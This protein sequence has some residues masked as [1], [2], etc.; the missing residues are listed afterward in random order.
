MGLTYAN[1][2]YVHLAAQRVGETLGLTA[3]SVPAYSGT[4]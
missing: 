4:V 1:R 3:M 2:K